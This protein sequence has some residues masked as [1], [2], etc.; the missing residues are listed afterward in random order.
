[1]S[2][3]ALPGRRAVAALALLATCL[4]LA[5][6]AAATHRGAGVADEVALQVSL[7]A[8]TLAGASHQ[9]VAR[10]NMDDGSPVAGVN[11]EFLREVDFLGPRLIRLGTATTDAFGTARIPINTTE[12]AL[13]VRAQFNGNDQY[14]AAEVSLEIRLP[15]TPASGPA[16]DEPPRA[17]L[18]LVAAVM[19]PLL[20]AIAAAMWLLLIGL[21]AMT[22]FAI[23]RDRQDS[24]VGK[25]GQP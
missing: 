10:V 5:A 21:T 20:A 8:A 15:A 12:S 23:R 18:A 16:T 19:P 11:V 7:Q 4:A 2:R 22:V 25:E 24:A 6:P 3:H 9:L 14:L 1:M 17:S 13:H